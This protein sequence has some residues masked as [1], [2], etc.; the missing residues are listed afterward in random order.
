LERKGIF[1][2]THVKKCA[3]VPDRDFADLADDIQS[4]NGKTFAVLDEECGKKMQE[5]ILAA[6]SEGDSVGGILETAVI[7]LPAG[8]GEPWFDTVEGL[9][10]HMLFSIPA[11]KGVE[12]GTGF[13]ITDLKGSAAN[14]Q[15]RM[16]D[17]K[18]VS[19][20][21][22]SGGI[23]GGITNGM[24]IL[25]RT[26]IKPTPTIFKPQDTVDFQS[27]TDTVLEPKGRHDPA[28]V[29]RARIVQDAATAIVLCDTLALRYGTDWLR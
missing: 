2:G 4:L 28:I 25:F 19:T 24:P 16:E 20:T 29:H 1:I 14:D 7:G 11:V 27:M 23:N 18:V 10:S 8:V 13:A 3:G 15:L 17:G 26:A 9:L 22:H 12:F 5:A 21:N 6:A